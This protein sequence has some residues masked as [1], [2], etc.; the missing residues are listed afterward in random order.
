M[1][2]VMLSKNNL[3]TVQEWNKSYIELIILYVHPTKLAV[4]LDHSQEPEIKDLR[5][6]RPQKM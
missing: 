5:P 3:Q 6:A 4:I 2:T 1:A